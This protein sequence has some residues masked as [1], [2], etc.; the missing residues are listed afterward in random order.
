MLRERSIPNNKNRNI[1]QINKTKKNLEKT[2]ASRCKGAEK[3]A[4]ETGFA[5]N[6]IKC[7]SSATS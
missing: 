4:V 2:N 7:R 6:M 1:W 3:G 5:R